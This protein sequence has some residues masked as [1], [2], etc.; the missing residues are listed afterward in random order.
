MCANSMS[1]ASLMATESA[2]SI[3]RDNAG[4][5]ALDYN[6]MLTSPGSSA[7]PVVCCLPQHNAALSL[8]HECGTQP[9]QQTA[10]VRQ[11]S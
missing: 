2:G 8:R 11:S 1:Y 6:H 4:I 9:L 3:Q 5:N 7:S 10:P